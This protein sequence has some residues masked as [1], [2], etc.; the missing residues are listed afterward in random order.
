MLPQDLQI[1]TVFSSEDSAVV[2]EQTVELVA[3]AKH[4]KIAGI[5]DHFESFM[6]HRYEEYVQA[7]RK[8]GLLVGTE[9]NS[10]QKEIRAAFC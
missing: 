10:H 9:V 2:K 6:P 3:F 1:H 8:A 5:S 7:V 4:A